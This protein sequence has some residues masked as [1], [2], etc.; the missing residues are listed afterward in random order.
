MNAIATQNTLPGIPEQQS[1]MTPM[2]MVA[3]AVQQGADI[4]KIQRLMDL[5]DRYEASEARKAYVEALANFKRNPPRVLKDRL[6]S[7]YK[8]KYASLGNLVNTVNASLGEHGLNARWSLNQSEKTIEVTCILSHALGHSESVMLS[9][10]PDTSGAKNPLQQ[11][12]SAITYLEGATFQAITGIVASDEDDDGNG[13][14]PKAQVQTP[15]GYD[16]WKADMTAL[17][18]EGL[19]KLQDAWGKS[20]PE[21]R[22]HVVKNDEQWWADTKRKAGKVQ[23]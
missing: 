6:N 13:F 17:A 22:R 3:I 1:V 16:N 5:R 10:P 9:S 20:S 18:D 21:F 14:Q 7:Q 8:S 23:S 12:K 4:E 15:D 11:I 19:P 2:Q